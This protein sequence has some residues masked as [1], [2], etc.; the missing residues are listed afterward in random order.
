MHIENYI[1]ELQRHSIEYKCNVLLSNYC[2][3]Y[4]VED[5]GAYIFR[6]NLTFR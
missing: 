4:T 2:T 5:N 3:V 1:A 6:I